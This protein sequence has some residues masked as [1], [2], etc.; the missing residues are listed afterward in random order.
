MKEIR[1]KNLKVGDVFFNE[2]ITVDGER[3]ECKCKL[4]EHRN[5]TQSVIENDG[6]WILINSEEIVKTK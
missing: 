3:V 5:N 4:I 6:L 1:L 2:G